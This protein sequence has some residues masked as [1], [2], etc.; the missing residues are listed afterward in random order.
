MVG[1]PTAT[2]RYQP[3]TPGC[4]VAPP[5]FTYTFHTQTR[6]HSH[7]GDLKRNT[8]H[9]DNTTQHIHAGEPHAL[10]ISKP[11]KYTHV[12]TSSS[13]LFQWICFEWPSVYHTARLCSPAQ[14]L[15][16]N[17]NGRW[18]ASGTVPRFKCLPYPSRATQQVWWASGT[19]SWL[20]MA[21]P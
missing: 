14:T 19:T 20:W 13:Q 1:P 7:T 10:N 11:G 21:G 12:R 5:L 17:F 9:R 4:S 3:H 8:N 6:T 15:A 16:S 2:F 18:T